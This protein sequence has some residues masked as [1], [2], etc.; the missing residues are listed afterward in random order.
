MG[1]NAVN[2]QDSRSAML[3]ELQDL[4]NSVRAAKQELALYSESDPERLTA[5]S[6]P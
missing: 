1:S 5:M 4:E 3:A 2:D 6:K